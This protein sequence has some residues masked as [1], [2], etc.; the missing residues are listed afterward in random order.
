MESVKNLWLGHRSCLAFVV[1]TTEIITFF[2]SMLNRDVYEFFVEENWPRFTEDSF[3][4]FVERFNF[5][6]ECERRFQFRG[7]VRH[8]FSRTSD[9]WRAVRSSD[10]NFRRV[11]RVWLD[12]EF[13]LRVC[14]NCTQPM[15]GELIMWVYLFLVGP[16]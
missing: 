10:R 11:Y 5:R 2:P 13:Q 6:C 12:E 3:R 4:R 7:R 9:K 14:L 8:L 1:L 15:P 16:D